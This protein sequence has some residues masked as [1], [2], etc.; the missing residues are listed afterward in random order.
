MRLDL[1]SSPWERLRFAVRQ[2]CQLRWPSA[3]HLDGTYSC[4]QDDIADLRIIAHDAGSGCGLPFGAAFYSHSD[5]EGVPRM[6]TAEQ[7]QSLY[8]ALR[9]YVLHLRYYTAGEVTTPPQQPV[10]VGE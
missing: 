2:G 5:I 1:R 10:I 4:D 6:L 9:D 8:V 3:P 7:A